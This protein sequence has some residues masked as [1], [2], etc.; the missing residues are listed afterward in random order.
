MLHY[1]TDA[2]TINVVKRRLL[3]REMFSTEQRIRLPQHHSIKR[4]L[5]SVFRKH[6]TD[7][8]VDNADKLQ[9]F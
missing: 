8:F 3:Q 2:L 9:S 6:V 5:Y 1:N 4:I 7:I